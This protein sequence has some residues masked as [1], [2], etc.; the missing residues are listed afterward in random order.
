MFFITAFERLPI[1]LG[2]FDVG[3]ISV[4]GYFDN[5]A[6]AV[7]RLHKNACDMHELLY[8]YAIVEE[9]PA[10]IHPTVKSY[11]YFAY[12]KKRDGFFEIDEPQ[13]LVGWCNFALG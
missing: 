8:D 4:F 9:I 2:A 1:D 5:Y 13:D 10:G 3:R 6:D 11:Q 7:E 12:D